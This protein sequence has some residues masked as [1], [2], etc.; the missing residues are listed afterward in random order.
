MSGSATTSARHRKLRASTIDMD[1]TESRLLDEG[2]ISL[3]KKAV[4][5]P[6]IPQRCRQLVCSRGWAITIL[7]LM[8]LF[9]VLIAIIASFARPQPTVCPDVS[10]IKQS[11]TSPTT[12]PAPQY[13]STNGQSFP[14]KHLKLPRSV[15]PVSYDIHMHPNISEQTF[16]GKV[17]ILADVAEATDFIVF[18]IKDLKIPHFSVQSKKSGQT[19]LTSEYLEYKHAEQFYIKLKVKLQRG[20]QIQLDVTFEGQLIEKLSGFYRSVYKTLSGE[21]RAI[22]TTHFE[23]TDARAAFPCFD[24]PEFKA[25]FTM[26]MVRDGSHISL[27]NMPLRQTEPLGG[28]GLV[29]DRFEESVKMSTYLVAF[30][31]CDYANISKTMDNGVKV[32]VYTPPEQIDQAQFALEGAVKA[33]KYYNDFFGVPY[34]LPKQDLVAVPDFAA[35]AME[36]WGLIIYRMTAILYDEKVSSLANKQWVAVVVAH[37]LAHQ[38]FGNLVTMEWWDDL[39]LNEGFATYVQ[40]IGADIID[41][42]F[43]MQDQF[44]LEVQSAMYLDSFSNSHPIHVPVND[45]SQINEIFDKI[46]YSKGASILHMLATFLGEDNFKSGL[47]AYL[48]KH[49]YGNARTN[50]LWAALQEA[51]HDIGVDVTAIMDTWTKQMGYPV[52]TLA[53][54]N[55]QLVL[56]Q[57]HFLLNSQAV[58][59]SGEF[60]SPYSYKW[61]IPFSMT[62]SVNSGSATTVWMNMSSVSIP[63]PEGITWIKGNPNVTGFYR[64]NY[65]SDMWKMI[66]QQLLADHKVFTAA[67]RAGYIDDA[68]TLVRAGKLSLK[69]ALDLTKYLEK[70]TDY[71]PWRTAIDNLNFIEHLIYYKE[72]FSTYKKYM[73]KLINPLVTS[74]GWK[75]TGSHLQRF[76]RGH[77]L[78]LGVDLGNKEVIAKGKE[79]FQKWKTD[80]ASLSPNLKNV[81]YKAGVENGD[82]ADWQFCW[83]QYNATNVPSEK[84]KLLNAMTYTKD[85][86]QIELYLGYSLDK[87]KV[88][89]QDSISVITGLASS[90]SGQLR[91]WRF[92]EQNY[93]E[94]YK[95]YGVGSF[96]FPNLVKGVTGSFRTEFD[97]NEVKSFFSTREV[98]SAKR[99]VQQTLEKIN[100]NINW[101][102]NHEQEITDWLKENAS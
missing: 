87:L 23:P 75:D 43:K 29:V 59:D 78:H 20:E 10:Q 54:Q 79:L 58:D 92:L 57:E 14:W 70:E 48:K 69:T 73:L 95:R 9:L 39:W 15:I 100:M 99:A 6:S 76:L 77:I 8:G 88:R 47:T 94:L 1:D 85:V 64:V 89:S 41:E 50:D 24:E 93:D 96:Q 30:V 62:T 98:G 46:S 63:Y 55:G 4:Y 18:H 71:I 68:F 40:Y 91:A 13:I 84:A 3:N 83:D 34:P 53:K 49:K 72:I 101:M 32:T 81:V 19:I 21:E 22:A 86:R 42:T 28:N 31:I 66:S 82:E 5:E 61:Y 38:W 90:P 97:Y 37:E 45:P 35:G 2:E 27:F 11:D 52:V 60:T 36:N 17:T 65:D 33:L 80:P 26:N 44:V 16:K 12:T 51:S 74:L 25:M 102:K 67:D 7:V 56:T